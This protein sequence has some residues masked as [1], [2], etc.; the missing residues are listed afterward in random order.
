MCLKWR[1]WV[2][3]FAFSIQNLNPISIYLPSRTRNSP[4]FLLGSHFPNLN[5]P[6]CRINHPPMTK[7]HRKTGSVVASESHS[8]TTLDCYTE[9][10]EQIAT[11]GQCLRRRNDFVNP[12]QSPFVEMDALT[13]AAL[14]PTY[15]SHPNLAASCTIT[16]CFAHF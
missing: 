9:S 16:E 14:W 4:D 10:S 12:T 1:G 6:L 11:S 7:S 8:R 15:S 2:H 3:R 13:S 5:G